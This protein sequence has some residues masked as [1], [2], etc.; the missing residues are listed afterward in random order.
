MCFN[1]MEKYD[2]FCLYSYQ[3]VFVANNFLSNSC[4]SSSFLQIQLLLG[5]E[6]AIS[7]G[8][9]KKDER[10]SAVGE[11]KVSLFFLFIA[12]KWLHRCTYLFWTSLEMSF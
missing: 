12:Q 7:V 3:I 10:M 9:Q 5:Q 1:G 4:F 6:S 8:W 2:I 11:I